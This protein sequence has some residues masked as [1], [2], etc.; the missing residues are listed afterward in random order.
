MSAL[1]GTGIGGLIAVHSFHSA[2]RT[3][4]TRQLAVWEAAT[5]GAMISIC[6]VGSYA[7]V[8]IHAMYRDRDGRN[9][10]VCMCVL[11][12]HAFVLTVA[13][14]ATAAA[15]RCVLGGVL[16]CTPGPGRRAVAASTRC[17]PLD[18]HVGSILTAHPLCVCVLQ[19]CFP[20]RWHQGQPRPGLPKCS[21]LGLGCLPF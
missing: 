6:V 15:S 16:M 11:H 19:S 12:V 14:G 9:G 5:A 7:V 8:C 10:C 1:T 4:A 3:H 20:R 2:D 18:T 13:V 21:W 17:G